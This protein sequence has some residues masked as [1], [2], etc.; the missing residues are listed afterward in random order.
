[1][2]RTSIDGGN[3]KWKIGKDGIRLE[4]LEL[5]GLKRILAAGLQP[6]FRYRQTPA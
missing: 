5:I 4:N 3:E 6:I 1:M 2:E